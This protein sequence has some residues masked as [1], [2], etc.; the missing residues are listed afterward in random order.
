MANQELLAAYPEFEVIR[1]PEWHEVMRRAKRVQIP[2]DTVLMDRG[3]CCE[4][5][6]MLTDGTVRVY[7][8]SED[9]REMTLYR[10]STGGLC[11]LSLNSLLNR[12]PFQAVAR[13]ESDIT[14]QVLGYQDFQRAMQVSDVFRNLVLT[15]VTDRFCDMLQLVEETVFHNLDMRLACLLG[16]LFERNQTPTLSITHDN[17][18][19]ELGTSRE[20]ISRLLKEF[21]RKGC[22]TLAR[23]RIHLASPEGLR[24]FGH[25]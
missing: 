11:M 5:F 3:V 15:R 20:V 7:Q 12:R 17:I 1:S 4:H 13:S 9:G 19:R 16:H 22:I 21:E 18:A 25:E 10:I 23:G 2:S 24:W 8:P 6:L 14:V